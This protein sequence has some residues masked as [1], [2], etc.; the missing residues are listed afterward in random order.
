MTPVLEVVRD[1]LNGS[2]HDASHLFVAV[3]DPV[4]EVDLVVLTE[5]IDA[6]KESSAAVDD[7]VG[8][9]GPVN[10]VGGRSGEEVEENGPATMRD[11][12][13]V[14]AP[15]DASSATRIRRRYCPWPLST[16]TAMTGNIVSPT[17]IG[18]P[19]IAP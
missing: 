19:P 17:F 2:V 4:V 8:L 14:E 6:V 12:G 18:V 16:G 10:V 9:I 13:K 3:I 5:S 7:L 15:L 11:V 1:L